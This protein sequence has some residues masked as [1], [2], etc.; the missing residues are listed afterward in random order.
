MHNSL[1]SFLSQMSLSVVLVGMYDQEHEKLISTIMPKSSD[2]YKITPPDCAWLSESVRMIEVNEWSMRMSLPSEC[3][4]QSGQDEPS[5]CGKR[6]CEWRGKQWNI[7]LW[8]EQVNMG[9]YVPTSP[10]WR[11]A[12]LNIFSIKKKRQHFGRPSELW[13]DLDRQWAKRLVKNRHWPFSWRLCSSKALEVNRKWWAQSC[14]Q[15]VSWQIAQQKTHG[16]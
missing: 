4:N 5:C 14:Q 7:R 1:K 13:I 3:V 16:H 15:T 10:Q 12:Q 9:H 6:N 8:M 2:D 11:M